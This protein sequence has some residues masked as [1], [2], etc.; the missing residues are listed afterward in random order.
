MSSENNV[1]VPG[2]LRHL[3]NKLRKQTDVDG[4]TS[5]GTSKKPVPWPC[6]VSVTTTD[7]DVKVRLTRDPT[8]TSLTF[9]RREWSAF[10]E[11]VKNGEFDL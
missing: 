11:G 1:Y 9:T 10:I 6:C 5:F 3:Y 7:K 4:F 8:K 2:S